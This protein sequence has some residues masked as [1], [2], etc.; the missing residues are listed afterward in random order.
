MVWLTSYDVSE[1]VQ[2]TVCWGFAYG[3]LVAFLPRGQSLG[4]E[5][6][7]HCFTILHTIWRCSIYY[8]K[9]PDKGTVVVS[10]KARHKFPKLLPSNWVAFDP[11]YTGMVFILSVDHQLGAPLHTAHSIANTEG[12]NAGMLQLH[13]HKCERS[14]FPEFS[15]VIVLHFPPI[16]EPRDSG[17]RS[18]SSLH[19]QANLLSL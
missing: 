16:E 15:G 11:G 10:M 1:S 9:L 7:V 17:G 4:L 6:N 14:I 13:R 2:G 5:N 3:C 19:H 12:I 8:L 18:A